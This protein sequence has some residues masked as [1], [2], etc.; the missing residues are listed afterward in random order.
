MTQCY[1]PPS[2]AFLWDTRPRMNAARAHTHTH[3]HTHTQT[4]THTHTKTDT[5]THTELAAERDTDATLAAESD[6]C[7]SRRSATSQL[8]GPTPPTPTPTPTALLLQQP[9]PPTLTPQSLTTRPCVA[10]A[11]IDTTTRMAV[12]A[13]EGL[14]SNQQ[15]REWYPALHKAPPLPSRL[16][17]YHSLLPTSA[18]QVCGGGHALDMED[19][20]TLRLRAIE[21]LLLYNNQSQLPLACSLLHALPPC[22]RT[23]EIG[24]IVC[25][26][27][28]VCAWGGRCVMCLGEINRIACTHTHTLAHTHTHTHIHTHLCIRQ[29]KRRRTCIMTS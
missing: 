26:L 19:S 25:V 1:V 21:L 13:R 11:K 20:E 22:P 7:N 29:L 9:P 8:S 28:Y 17:P 12:C 10:P 5:H 4:H 6:R 24:L 14:P 2:T 23:P 18:G 3:T 27:G 16:L 15:I